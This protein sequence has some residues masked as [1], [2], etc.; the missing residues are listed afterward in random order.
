MNW[1]GLFKVLGI[2]VS[3]LLLWYMVSRAGIADLRNTLFL[4][5]PTS[6]FLL[7]TLQIIT[8]FG[9]ALLWQIPL[10]RCS[11]SIAF[12]R[13]LR[14]NLS[15]S[16]VETLTPSVKFGGEAVKLAL[17]KK[18]CGCSPSRMASL[19]A[20]HTY[21]WLMP[22]MVISS[23]LL[24]AGALPDAFSGPWILFISLVL[25]LFPA[26]WRILRPQQFSQVR[27]PMLLP[28]VL[29]FLL[30]LLYPIKVLIALSSL[31]IQGIS[32]IQAAGSV[33][34][35]YLIGLLPFFPGGLGGFEAAMS[36]VLI[37]H[38]L[39]PVEASAA[40]LVTR[41]GTF[42]FPLLLSVP[43][44]LTLMKNPRASL[45]LYKGVSP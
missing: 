14:I 43:A 41:L 1:R 38:G 42:W 5:K 6:L 32:Y 27:F 25:I 35:G 40:A 44:A 45:H 29:S 10:R 3:L 15:G 34:A 4:V 13:T 28:L 20:L 23:I 19:A 12:L 30:W 36:Y 22:F 24:L 31:Q 18:A 33:F 16:L 37:Q 9:S 21:L 7:F 8:I 39:S 2:P 26:G 17:F 11:K